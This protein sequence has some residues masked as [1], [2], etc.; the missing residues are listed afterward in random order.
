MG[1]EG[2]DR[3]KQRSGEINPS[4]D[5]I[6]DRGHDSPA[7]EPGIVPIGPNEIS[8]GEI[9]RGNAWLGK[10]VTPFCDILQ[11]QS[12]QFQSTKPLRA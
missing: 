8:G 10:F 11:F 6:L 4:P 1:I 7:R 3:Q 2:G 9:E 12:A 5:R